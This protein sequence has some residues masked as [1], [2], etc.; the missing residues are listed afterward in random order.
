MSNVDKIKKKMLEWRDF[1]GADIFY[2]EEI[3][4]AKSKR[5]LKKILDDYFK[6]MEL[7]ECDARSHFNEFVKALR[8][9]D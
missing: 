8:L 4:A 1:Y 3:G 6:H 9:D 5:D 2:S 7:R